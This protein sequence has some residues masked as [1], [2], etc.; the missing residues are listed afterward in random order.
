FMKKIIKRVLIALNL[1]NLDSPDLVSLLRAIA[2]GLT[3]NPNFLPADLAKMPVS[4][5]DMLSQATALET[6][7]ITRE[8]NK[9]GALTALEL[10]Q[11]ATVQN[12]LLDTARFV[13]G[14]ANK[15]AAGD[16]AIA[17]MIIDSVGFKIKKAFTPHQRSFEVV[18]MSEKQVHLRTVSAGVRT[19]YLWQWSDDDAK[20][21]SF[22]I[23]TIG[24]EV[25]ITNL[26]SGTNYSFRF[27]AIV[28]II[29]GK[30]TVEIG[31]E[32]PLWSDVITTI[33]S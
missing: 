27:A 9:S 19:A 31:S 29:H 3:G 6:T 14:L 4:I 30:P 24:A 33:V 2:K 32:Q 20:T 5:A 8:M 17:M 13:E 12:T 11:S 7:H 23:V 16:S 1:R 18:K 25:I 10:N 15:K 28:P 22:P 26:K 21:W